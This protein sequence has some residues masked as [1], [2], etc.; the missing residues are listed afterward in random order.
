MGSIAP[1][2]PPRAGRA[3]WGLVR[4][5]FR[6]LYNELAF[7]YDTVSWIVSLGQWRSWQR[8]AL[9]HLHG[10][11]ILELAHGPGS[12]QIDLSEAGYHSVALDLSRSMGR[13]ARRKLRRHG[14]TPR[15]VRASALA[16]PFPGEHF[17]S[18]V[19]TFPT[20]F[21]IAPATLAEIHRVLQPGGR[22]VVVFN[23]VLTSGGAARDALEFA[24]RITGQRG[25]W[26]VNVE[27]RLA[28]AGFTAQM[29]TE[30]LKRSTVLLFIADKR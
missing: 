20:E 25:P 6:L 12:F 30:E 8:C 11:T 14:L 22:L 15:L 18:V 2:N 28:A 5:G 27:E 4:F 13:I 16:I 21:I 9:P 19:S 24:Y 26:P 17:S 7:T 10:D 1:N 29:I 23:G 3:W